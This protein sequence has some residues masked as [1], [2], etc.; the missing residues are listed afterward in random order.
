MKC[1]LGWGIVIATAVF[2]SGLLFAEP[3]QG[4][5]AATPAGGPPAGAPP[6]TRPLPAGQPMGL[7]MPSREMLQQAGATVEQIE[8]LTQYQQSLLQKQ[9][10]LRAAMEKAN[11]LKQDLDAFIKHENDEASRRTAARAQLV[12][13]LD[14]MEETLK[15]MGAQLA[16]LTAPK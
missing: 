14:A 3:P 11:Q 7:R 8:A 6:V 2:G 1:N 9:T 12:S 10:D 15:R 13:R 5:G 4:G 16:S